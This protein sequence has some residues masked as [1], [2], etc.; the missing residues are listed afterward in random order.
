MDV[1]NLRLS[2]ITLDNPLGN[3][4]NYTSLYVNDTY[5]Y[6]GGVGQRYLIK[7]SSAISL[8][9]NR[10]SFAQKFVNI[11]IENGPA[12]LD[13][14]SWGWLDSELNGYDENNF[15]L[16]KYNSS[17]GWLM[18]N[19]TP[20]ITGNRLSAAN[21]SPQGNEGNV[22]G[23][24]EFN[25]LCDSCA[26]CTSKL[27]DPSCNV[28]NLTADISSVSGT[29][30]DNPVNFS[31]KVFDCQGHL[32]DGDGSGT[33]Y[34]IYLLGKQ[35]NTI[36]NCNVSDFEYGFF[37]NLSSNNTFANN[38]VYENKIGFYI[39]SSPNNSFVNNTVWTGQ[40]YG[41]Q[42]SSSNNLTFINNTAYD[43]DGGGFSFYNCPNMTLRYNRAYNT[44]YGF[45]FSH[46]SGTVSDGDIAYGNTCLLY[47][48]PS[49]RDS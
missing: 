49:P 38:N 34:G 20:D 35:N 48:S 21:L 9:P 42:G 18:I 16:W 11:T 13:S 39:V 22:Y 12:E 37:L 24:F 44:G 45:E 2:N 6:I 8:P 29:C 23:I 32:I 31:N 28:V 43:Y 40:D 7:W 14:V 15:Q 10:V 33:D 46:C 3:F 36:R 17:T 5:G 4:V 19:G 26:S 47:T 25:C 30:I 1:Y 41:F 27:N